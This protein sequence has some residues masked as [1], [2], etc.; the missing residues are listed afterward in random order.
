MTTGEGATAAGLSAHVRSD[1]RGVDVTLRVAPGETVAIMGPNGAGKSTLLA[2][3]AGMLRPDEAEI[4]LDGAVLADARTWVRPHR[5]GIALLAQD[6]LLFPH[7]D[8][9]ENVAFGPRSAGVPRTQARETARRWLDDVG[10]GDL[11]DRRPSAL[12]GGQAQRVALARALAT[13]PRLLL[14]D[15][16][17]AALDVT[18]APAMRRLL[19]DVLAERSTLL[20]THDVLDALTLADRVVVIE[21]GRV[22]EDG[23][24]HQVLARPRSA[25]AARVAGLDLLRG[26]VRD[27][28]V[29]TESGHV[30]VG[31][32]DEPL[33]EGAGAVAVFSPSAVSVHREPP[34]GRPRNVLST[35][36]G[37]LQQQG[38]RVR[39]HT[40]VADAE[41]TLT[42][43]SELGLAPGRPVHLAVK[44]TEVA[45]H[46]E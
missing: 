32:A 40:E 27:G 20:V 10:V 9:V 1:E 34:G 6:A 28:A 45:L 35:V 39:V 46:P 12:S 30:L 33:R 14:L 8:A 26:R 17:M 22:T 37:H 2:A 24:T 41:V 19:R 44:A 4:G 29:V 15:E 13:G 36:V 18:V 43:A 23:P 31:H 7:L 25:F 42:A 5:R 3:V 38:D 16:P 11:A 21:D